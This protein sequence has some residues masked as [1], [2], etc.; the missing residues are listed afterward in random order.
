MKSKAFICKPHC[1]KHPAFLNNTKAKKYKTS[2]DFMT[3]EE[4]ISINKPRI[5]GFC[6]TAMNSSG[7]MA[8]NHLKEQKKFEVV[9][10]IVQLQDRPVEWL[11]IV[12]TKSHSR[13][14]IETET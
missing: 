14:S 9:K 11:N 3:M 4:N 2:N 1:R 6:K 12:L 13:P 5:S 8:I 7:R 10:E